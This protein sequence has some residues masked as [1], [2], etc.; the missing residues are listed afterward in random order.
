MV[1][2]A[3]VVASVVVSG[4]VATVVVG[5]GGG[6]EVLCIVVGVG[7]A[8]GGRSVPVQLPRGSNATSVIASGAIKLVSRGGLG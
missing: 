2:V 7:S 3:S 6:S 4:G 1:V 5:D 8:I